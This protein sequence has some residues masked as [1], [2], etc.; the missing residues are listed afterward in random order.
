MDIHRTPTH[1]LTITVP[2]RLDDINSADQDRAVQDVIHL[3]LAASRARYQ[4]YV[5]D[6]PNVE[7]TEYAPPLTKEDFR[8]ADVKA[9][10]SAQEPHRDLSMEDL[11]QGAT[12]I[13]KALRKP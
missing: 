9:A 3:A 12:L 8:A 13:F 4:D 1:I 7:L 2:L 6:D 11:I 10:K 5:C